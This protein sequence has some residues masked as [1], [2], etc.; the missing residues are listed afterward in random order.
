MEFKNIKDFT[1][2]G[3]SLTKIYHSGGVIW[4]SIPMSDLVRVKSSDKIYKIARKES[5]RYVTNLS[6]HIILNNAKG[7]ELNY[8]DYVSHCKFNIFSNGGPRG[9][10]TYAD[11]YIHFKD[12]S[13]SR[14]SISIRYVVD[15]SAGDVM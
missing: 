13:V 14:R 8:D 6:D 1:S 9:S 15:S 10:Y 11:Y 5:M 3:K 7:E 4:E 2:G 12:G